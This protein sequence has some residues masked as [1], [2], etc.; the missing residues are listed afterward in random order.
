MI[1]NGCSPDVLRD[2]LGSRH[3]A[4]SQM[5]FAQVNTGA[6]PGTRTPNPRIPYARFGRSSFLIL[7]ACSVTLEPRSIP[8]HTHA[9]QLFAAPGP[10]SLCVTRWSHQNARWE[11]IR[12]TTRWFHRTKI[13]KSRL[14]WWGRVRRQGLEPRTRGLRVDCSG[15]PNALPAP[16]SQ[17]SA[18]NARNAH[19]CGLRSF[20]EPFH[21][22]PGPAREVRHS[23]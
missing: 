15:A 11:R 8:L 2:A 7:I 13:T 1:T 14:A 19:E 23:K 17:E 16:T 20:H 9:L 12:G 18:R 3:I 22:V 21:A 10:R 4:T 5:V 6:P